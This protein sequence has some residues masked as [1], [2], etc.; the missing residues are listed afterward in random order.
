MVILTH[1]F[2]SVFLKG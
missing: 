1:P 2:F